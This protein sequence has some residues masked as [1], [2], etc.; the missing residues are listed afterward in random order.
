MDRFESCMNL[1]R[2]V[3]HLLRQVLHLFRQVVKL[4]YR[5]LQPAQYMATC[6]YRNKFTV[7]VPYALPYF[8]VWSSETNTHAFGAGGGRERTGRILWQSI[9]SRGI[10]WPRG[11]RASLA[12]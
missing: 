10:V 11:H 12:G 4:Y 2:Q 9:A 1:F 3:L 8:E 5:L 7:Y 6:Q